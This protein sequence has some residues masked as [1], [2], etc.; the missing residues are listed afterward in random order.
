MIFEHGKY[1]YKQLLLFVKLVLPVCILSG[2]NA[3][4]EKREIEPAFY[5]WKSVFEISSYEQ[6]KIDSLKVKTL[7]IKFF[8]V[9][10]KAELEQ[11]V[12]IAKLQ[13]AN[14]QLPEKVAVIPT[15]FIT[16]ECIQKIHS[17]QITELAN[18]IFS[19]TD[20]I[21]KTNSFIK[22]KEIQF[23][24]DWTASTRSNYFLLL[25]K[26]NS[27]YK[28]S[29][30]II[31]ATIR[32]HQIKFLN[33]TG[34][35]PVNRGLLMCYNMGNLKNPAT[36]NSIIETEELKKYTANLSAY[37]L[38][39]DVALPL[40]EWKV[41]FRNNVYSGLI[42]NLNNT[43]LTPAVALQNNNRFTILKDTTIAGYDLKKGDVLRHEQSSYKEI[44]NTAAV[45]GSQL[46]N[47]SLRVSLYHLD[48]VILKKYAAHELETLYNSLR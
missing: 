3:Q 13:T 15:V 21:A 48:S 45:I 20:E 18:N 2:C 5:Y 30:I 19:L 42:Q 41:L 25:Q 40:F 46:K 29:G 35:P 31:S 24:C 4:K 22:L 37:P 11:P 36:G 17:S 28:D 39:L 9:G 8:D 32:L 43:L 12:P 1:T 14:F 23:D 6:Q 38:P 34:V 33:K 26:M 10:W 16:N 27:L 47:T 7:Y 44:L